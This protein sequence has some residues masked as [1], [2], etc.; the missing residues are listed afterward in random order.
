[1]RRGE[2]GP[3]GH[4]RVSGRKCLGGGAVRRMRRPGQGVDGRLGDDAVVV[5][6]DARRVRVGAREDV[7]ADEPP[8]E[9]LVESPLLGLRGGIEALA[10]GAGSCGARRAP[11]TTT[12]PPEQPGSYSVCAFTG[13]VVRVPKNGEVGVTMWNAEYAIVPV[14]LRRNPWPPVT[15]RH[16]VDV[17][18]PAAVKV[19]SRR[20]GETEL[21]MSSDSV[22]SVFGVN[23]NVAPDC[24]LKL[25]SWNWNAVAGPVSG[26]A[27]SSS[28]LTEGVTGGLPGNSNAESVHLVP[29]PRDQHLPGARVEEEG[30]GE[31]HSR[32]GTGPRKAPAV[33]A[34]ETGL[35][36]RRRRGGARRHAQ[37]ETI[38]VTPA[39]RRVSPC[40]TAA[41][42]AFTAQKGTTS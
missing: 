10:A 3:A 5:R 39:A 25:Y 15:R 1:M 21:P 24:G 4:E 31:V 11:N 16:A 42:Y 2:R 36:R 22:A 38:A 29:D 13:P 23:V 27:R 33:P 6:G 28:T 40:R 12:P 14:A 18:G 26:A 32:R 7:L 8:A 20:V 37:G 34:G 9:G 41:L 19:V 17:G 35:E 30:R